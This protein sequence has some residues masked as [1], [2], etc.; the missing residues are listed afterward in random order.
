M[1]LYFLLHTSSRAPEL[2]SSV[3]LQVHRHARHQQVLAGANTLRSFNQSRYSKTE[4]GVA[5]GRHAHSLNI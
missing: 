4:F 2:A 3:G 1:Q 5:A